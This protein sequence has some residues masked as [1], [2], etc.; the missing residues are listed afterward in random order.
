M[1]RASCEAL[2]LS[3]PSFGEVYGIGRFDA[4][5]FYTSQ[6]VLL[7]C[8]AWLAFHACST[9]HPRLTELC[10]IRMLRLAFLLAVVLFL[11]KWCSEQRLAIG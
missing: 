1:G 3:Y 7:C 11:L 4:V 6:D 10:H 9:C 8:V 2:S 5:T